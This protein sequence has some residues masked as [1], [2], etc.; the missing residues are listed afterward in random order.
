MALIDFRFYSNSLM[1]NVSAKAIIPFDGEKG[2]QKE[3][4]TLYLLHGLTGDDMDWLLN[5][6]IYSH[7]QKRG[8]AVIIPNGENSFYCDNDSTQYPHG[9]FIGRDIVEASRALFR[10]SH[11][12][13]DTFI[14]GLS[15][16]GY[17]AI[18]CGLEFSDIFGWVGGFSPALI[19]RWSQET[20]FHEDRKP[21]HEWTVFGE[22]NK[23]DGSKKDPLYLVDKIAKEHPQ[24]MPHL[25]L[26][27]GTEDRLITPTRELRD[28]IESRGFPVRYFEGPGEHDFK[29]WNISIV[30]FLDW[31]GITE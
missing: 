23:I 25:F 29:F 27:C 14:A 15:M 31:I 13:E 6:N 12:K 10:L 8:I 2:P 11:K 30:Q 20:W 28:Y 22:L 21:F 4:P 19:T 26:T 7:A 1:R 5:S 24:D 18:R 3:Y 17:G 9:Q 16:G